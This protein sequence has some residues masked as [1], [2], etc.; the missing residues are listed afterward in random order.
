VRLSWAAL[1]GQF[2]QEYADTA[3]F[4]RKF[5]GAL[6]KATA[7]YK[8]A[9]IETITGGLRLLPSLPP[10]KRTSVVVMAVEGA[11][12]G[13]GHRSLAALPAP[14][15]SPLPAEPAAANAG[16]AVDA[17]NGKA[18]A[19]PLP[20]FSPVIVEKLVSAKALEQVPGIAPGWDKYA[21]AERYK[22][23]VV[24]KGEMPRH[25]DA[26]FVG[27]VRSYTKGVRP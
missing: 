5:L 17:L 14:R 8:E 3:N 21:L 18:A 16:G 2:G 20:V 10:V 24:D 15:G 26:A 7:A 9:R 13:A 25:P 12:V 23:W 22:A 11:R 27:W 1:K 4:K 19:I 6:R